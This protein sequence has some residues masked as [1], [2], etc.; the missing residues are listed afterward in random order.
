VKSFEAHLADC[1]GLLPRRPVEQVD[2]LSSA[3]RELVEQV[4]ATSPFPTFA[5]SSM[6]GYAVRVAD[7]PGR[8][9]VVGEVAAGTAPDVEVAP[10]TAVR[11]MTGSAIPVGTEAVVRI[12][13]TSAHADEVEISVATKAGTF[14][15]GIGDDVKVGDVVLAAGQVIGAA[16]IAALAAHN[17]ETVSVCR[18]ARVAILSTGDE[19]V[20]HGSLAG[21]VQLVDSNGPGLATAVVAAGAEVVHVGQVSDDPDEF[22][23]AMDALPEADLVITSGGISMGAYDVVKAT[24]ATRG[25]TFETVAIQPGKPQAWGRYRDSVGFLGLPGNPVSALVSFELFGRAALGRERVTATATLVDP[26]ERSP[27]G[28]RQFLRGSLANG[29]VRLV[30]GPDSHLIVGLARA[31]CLVVIGE[32]HTALP[33]GAQVPVVLLNG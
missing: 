7:V 27:V 31:N 3:G 29:A 6:D 1:R 15:R 5:A 33:P 18:P 11:I 12:E 26:V 13:D 25:V 9:R 8:L 24:L 4:L 19:L 20:G 32:E 2:A 17:V 21:A 16:Q 14:V 28:M 30:S 22:I 10:G 23:A